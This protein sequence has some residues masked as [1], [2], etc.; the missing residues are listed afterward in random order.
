M[1]LLNPSGDKIYTVTD[2]TPQEIFGIATI[3][4]FGKLFKSKVIEDWVRE[5]LLMRISRLRMGRREFMLLATGIKE[6]EERKRRGKVRD[7][8]AGLK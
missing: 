3:N 7:L 1:E 6:V 4:R 5:F 8:F 2:V